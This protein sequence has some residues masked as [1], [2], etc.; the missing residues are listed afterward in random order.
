ML[1][2]TTL[3]IV[4]NAGRFITDKKI[5]I[6]KGLNMKEIEWE[7]HS[8]DTIRAYVSEF[9]LEV[10]YNKASGMYEAYFLDECIAYKNTQCEAEAACEAAFRQQ[11][12]ELYDK[13]VRC[14][15]CYGIGFTGKDAEPLKLHE[16]DYC[17]DCKGTG[18]QQSQAAE[19]GK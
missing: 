19:E 18:D 6:A 3:D 2:D 5:V 12:K 14:P 8:E 17:P 13:F 15:K 11:V 10:F 16:A 7:E 4:Q 9:N 1:V